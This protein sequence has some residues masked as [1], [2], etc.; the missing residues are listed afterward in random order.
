MGDLKTGDC[1]SCLRTYR[2]SLYHCGFGEMSYAYCD[3]CGELCI[4]SYWSN[5]LPLWPTGCSH[6]QEICSEFESMLKP[7]VCGG[8]FTKGASP[9]CPHCIQPLS[10]VHAANHIEQNSPGF[11]RGWIWQ[12]N[13]S[14]LHCIAIENPQHVG[15]MRTVN[16]PYL[17]NNGAT[18]DRDDSAR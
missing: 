4:L 12:R 5:K 14:G 10:A 13:W 6:H 17:E 1:E 9:R 8:R 3:T 11:A 18:H 15:V 7:C 2:Y 16:D